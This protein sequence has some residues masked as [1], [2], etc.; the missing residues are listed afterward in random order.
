MISKKNIWVL[1]LFSL[2]LVLSVYYITMP[3]D[4]I[5]SKTIKNNVKTTIK[6]ENDVLAALKI[7][8]E[9]ENN[10]KIKELQT[11]LS[12]E[13]KSKEEKNKAYDDLKTLNVIKGKEDELE[14]KIKEKY[15]VENFIKIEDDKVNVV[16][17]K[18]N[19]DETMVTNIMKLIQDNF[20]EKVF[21]S[22]KFQK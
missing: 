9:E 3:E 19:S 2:I 20:K 8:K 17:V 5:D 10:K 21:I 12:D 13:E 18:E 6:E 15:K 7:E 4:F 1:T 22:I 14:L 11:I 16:I